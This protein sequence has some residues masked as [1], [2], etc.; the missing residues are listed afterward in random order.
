MTN[1]DIL[2]FLSSNIP[3]LQ[4]LTIIIPILV[5]QSHQ[6]LLANIIIFRYILAIA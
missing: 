1:A 3:N 4:L 2:V 5:I 6:Y